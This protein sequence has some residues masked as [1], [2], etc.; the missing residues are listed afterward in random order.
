MEIT[1]FNL[2]EFIDV[3]ETHD[4]NE[5]SNI[6]ITAVECKPNAQIK[7]GTAY[8][9]LYEATVQDGPLDFQVSRDIPKDIV[10]LVTPIYRPEA[11]GIP[12][13]I[14]KDVHA[15]CLKLCKAVYRNVDTIINIIGVTGT[16][17]KTSVVQMAKQLME[18]TDTP[19]ASLG[20]LGLQYK[21]VDRK[22]GYTTPL[23]PTLFQILTELWHADVGT[24]FMEVSSQAIANRRVEGVDFNAGVLTGIGRDHIDFHGTESKY[25]ETKFNFIRD[26]FDN[27]ASI[28][29]NADDH[30]C[31][32]LAYELKRKDKTDVYTFGKN[33]ASNNLFILN[34]KDKT[35][36][37]SFDFKFKRHG[38]YETFLVRDIPLL[39]SA[40]AMNM[41]AAV[42][43][44]YLFNPYF[45]NF[46]K[47]LPKLRSI[48]GRLELFPLNNGV[49]A[50][51]DF[52]HTPDSL[53][54]VM[55]TANEI[56]GIGN[57]I[58]VFGCGGDR[59]KGKR[60]FMGE[61]AQEYADRVIVTSDNN[62]TEDFYDIADDITKKV[63]WRKKQLTVEKD[64][65]EAIKFA[66][67][68]STTNDIIVIA[69]KGHEDYQIEYD[70]RIQYSDVEQIKKYQKTTFLQ[71]LKNLFTFY[72]R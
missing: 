23:M 70:T 11:K 22:T 21:N 66:Y 50:L 12:Q 38:M 36:G 31:L 61:I 62:R 4:E 2:V 26:C 13:F 19:V 32:P 60:S 18:N 25:K 24:L 53:L 15:E 5:D 56:K 14:V 30:Q 49:T 41:A 45:E 37:M 28:I 52:A 64:R 33:D 47:S 16:N 17:G 35:R 34:Q 10:A 63:K 46:E 51:L 54:T 39:G 3:E 27:G 44:D 43:L 72:K 8:V 29:I 65:A 68:L 71:S 57:V 1:T 67:K 48:P 58:L 42:I 59:D 9:D 55:Q 6:V 40:N 20:T 7:P 69:G